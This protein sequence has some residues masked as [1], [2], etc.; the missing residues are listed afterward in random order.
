MPKKSNAQD[1]ILSFIVAFQKE[2][3]FS[4]TIREIADGI[5]YASVGC[6]HRHIQCLRENGLLREMNNPTPRAL[7]VNRVITSGLSPDQYQ[8]D[9]IH[10]CLKT[11]TGVSIILNCT[12]QYDRLSF[13]GFFCIIGKQNRTGNIIACQK[14]SEKD[15]ESLTERVS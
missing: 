9:A 10:I 8:G 12:P 13:D 5:G 2:H 3:G 1:H 4:P 15:Y 11:D 7:V 14:L 6:V